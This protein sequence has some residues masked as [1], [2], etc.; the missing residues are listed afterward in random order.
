M[1]GSSLVNIL[2]KYDSY[3]VVPSSREDTDL[4]ELNQTK[5]FIEKTNP[6]IVI[7]AAAMVGGIYANNT[8]RSKFIINNLKINMNI[9]ES[10]ISFQI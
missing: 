5:Y 1:V 10:S 4:F 6:D 3:Q 2:S 9:L 7:N 8:Q